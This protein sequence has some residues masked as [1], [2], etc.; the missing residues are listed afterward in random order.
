M[1][2]TIVTVMA[3]LSFF[4]VLGGMTYGQ[5]YSTRTICTACGGTGRD[6]SAEQTRDRYMNDTVLRFSYNTQCLLCRGR[7]FQED[8][9]SIDL[10]NDICPPGR[11]YTYGTPQPVYVS[12]AQGTFQ[13][14][15]NG[16]LNACCEMYVRFSTGNGVPYNPELAVKFLHAAAVNGHPVAQAEW[17][18]LTAIPVRY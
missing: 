16:D 10:A 6:K 1:K 17:Q 13:R 15:V 7:G 18:R 9:N 8:S 4:L 12:P 5:S 11:G 14:A 2:K 3:I